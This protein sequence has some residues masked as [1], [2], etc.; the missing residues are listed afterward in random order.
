MNI[1]KFFNQKKISFD[2][3]D[4]KIN[5]FDFNYDDFKI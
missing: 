2:L 3:K 4:F 1:R 5:T